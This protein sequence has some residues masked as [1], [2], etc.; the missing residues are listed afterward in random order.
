MG[1][2]AKGFIKWMISYALVVIALMLLPVFLITK[3]I[4]ALDGLV[5]YIFN[6]NQ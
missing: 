1:V 5:N 3:D 2:V 4:S 6:N